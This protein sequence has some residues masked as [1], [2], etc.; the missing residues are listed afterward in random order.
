LQSPWAAAIG[1]AQPRSGGR[2]SRPEE[3]TVGTDFGGSAAEIS[4]NM[5]R[6]ERAKPAILHPGKDLPAVSCNVALCG[7]NW[8]G[9]A[10][11]GAK[12]GMFFSAEPKKTYLISPVP[13]RSSGLCSRPAAGLP[14]FDSP[15][16]TTY[17]RF[18]LT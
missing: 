4:T 1:A 2:R 6:M 8:R 14:L 16:P 7:G 10:A 13:E 3:G 12:S 17:N 5:F 11:P 9:Y 18:I 15:M